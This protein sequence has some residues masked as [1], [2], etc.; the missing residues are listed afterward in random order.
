[1]L[2]V[3][4]DSFTSF[5]PNFIPILF[6]WWELDTFL[7]HSGHPCLVYKLRKK[8]FDILNMMFAIRIL[9]VDMLYMVKKITFYFYLLI[10]F[11]HEWC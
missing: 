8:L 6:S 2:A 3:N 10:T 9:G 4:N 7:I 11:N 5:F 1:M